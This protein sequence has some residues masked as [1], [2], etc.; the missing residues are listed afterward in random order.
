MVQWCNVL[1]CKSISDEHK[2][3][4]FF[5]FPKPLSNSWRTI[6]KRGMIF[7]KKPYVKSNI[8]D[9][10]KVFSWGYIFACT[11]KFVILVYLFIYS[12]IK[13]HFQ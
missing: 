5:A 6:L 1:T 3:I 9:D 11:K 7:Y 8:V 10:W 13:N 12:F 2:D 4:R